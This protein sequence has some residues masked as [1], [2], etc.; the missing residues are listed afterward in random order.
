[1]EDTRQSIELVHVLRHS[2]RPSPELEKALNTFV[3]P[4]LEQPRFSVRMLSSF[5]LDSSTNHSS[6]IYRARQDIER[7]NT[8]DFELGP[9]L[10][11]QRLA[12]GALKILMRIDDS[13]DRFGRDVN[14]I[15]YLKMM[16]D[17][18]ARI[19]EARIEKDIDSRNFT[20]FAIIP[21]SHALSDGEIKEPGVALLRGLKSESTKGLYQASLDGILGTNEERLVMPEYEQP[22][23]Q[24]S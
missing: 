12:G 18:R 24:A 10:A 2:L 20:F 21:G 7:G 8:V 19:P 17:T 4:G 23:E 3:K 13:I 6:G 14:G 15:S 16:E 5:V 22:L 11:A 1:M 9:H